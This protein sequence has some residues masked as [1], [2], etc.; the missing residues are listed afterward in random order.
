M[1]CHALK[2]QH[3]VL[4]EELVIEEWLQSNLCRCTSYK[5]IRQAVRMMYGRE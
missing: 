1:V 5:E 2:T 4:R 3:P